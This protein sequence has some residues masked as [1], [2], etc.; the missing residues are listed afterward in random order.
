MDKCDVAIIGAGPYGLSAAAHLRRIAGLDIRLFGE[1]MSFWQRHMPERMLLRSPWVAS[2]IADPDKQL[3]LDMYRSATAPSALSEPVPVAEF[4][5]YGHWLLEQLAVRPE[6]NVTQVDVGPG[7]YRL[8]LANGNTLAARR[9]VVAG[10]I[11]PFAYRPDMFKG[12]PSELVTHTSEQR[13]FE[14][15]ADKEVMVVGAGQSAL[16]AAGFMRAGG[17]RVAVLIR[18]P[19]VHWL[20]KKRQWLH[21]KAVRWMLYG[22]G[23]IGPAGVSIFVQH[24]NLFR[25]LPRGI[26]DWWGPR[27]VRPAVF[28]RLMANTDVAI[29][30]SRFPVHARAEK[31]RVRVYLN[32]GSDRLVDHVVLGTGY[33]VDVSK[34]PFLSPSVVERIER[35]NGYPVLGRGFETTSAALHIL[36]APASWS[37]GPI[38]R[39]VAGTEFAGRALMRNV[40]QASRRSSTARNRAGMPEAEYGSV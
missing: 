13:N 22:K 14:A 39:F 5:R 40:K 3:T 8:C 2:S 32:D 11:Q 30:T 20:G 18:N 33:R 12:F 38:M 1:P 36:G 6:G 28:D 23:D 35:V 26:Q 37:F 10:G 25:R 19:M 31:D 27:A 24:P 16:E 21:S 29:Q 4:I 9:V 34:Y 7:G 15:F 17:A